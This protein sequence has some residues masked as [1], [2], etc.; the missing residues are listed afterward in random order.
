MK[1]LQ[2]YKET[3][4]KENRKAQ[5]SVLDGNVDESDIMTMVFDI[6][7]KR[8]KFE[9]NLKERMILYLGFLGPILKCL[10]CRFFD[11]DHMIHM[12]KIFAK[13]KSRLDQ[14]CNIIEI[15]DQVRKSENF[16]RNF[17]CRQQK[18]LLKFD[19]SNIVDGNSEESG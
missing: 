3:K 1:K 18:I 14:D 4:I 5:E 10:R 2:T 7:S 6:F 17:L 8:K 11:Y 12:T 16:Q 19:H 15:M 13:A 9:Y